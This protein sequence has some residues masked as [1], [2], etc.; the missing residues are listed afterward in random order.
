M[1]AGNIIQTEFVYCTNSVSIDTNNTYTDITGSS[2]TITPKF[3]NS[4]ILVETFCQV[5]LGN[6]VSANTW[7]SCN[8]RLLRGSTVI[9]PPDSGGTNDYFVATYG[10]D[11][12][13]EM[14][15]GM[16][17]QVDTPNTTSATTYKLQCNMRHGYDADSL[18]Y[19][20]R[21]GRGMI[22]ATEISQ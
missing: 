3:S 15:Y 11:A 16:L 4:K 19:V 22:K 1:P 14:M 2:V 12:S 21:Y 20:N 9:T 13:R 7:S 18:I 8:M 10:G 6:N 17:S 5:Y